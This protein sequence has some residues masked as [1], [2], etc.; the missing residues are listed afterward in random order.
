MI[1]L[2]DKEIIDEKI[3]NDE[4][5]ISDSD[6]VEDLPNGKK[7]LAKNSI[8]MLIYNV[9]NVLVPFIYGIYVARVLPENLIGEVTIAQNIAQYF[10]ILAFLGIPTYG[11]REISKNRGNKE[12]T[13]KIFTELFIINFIS[14][15][16]FA[17]IYFGLICLVPSYRSNLVLFLITG[18]LILFNILDITWLYEGLEE[19]GFISLRNLIFKILSIIFLFIFVK[20]ENDYLIYATIHVG[21]LGFNYLT[22]ML[23]HRKYVRFDFK[24][25]N[26]KQHIKPILFLVVVN[27]AIEIY[28]LVDVT[29]IGIFKNSESV[30]FYSY[31]SKTQKI[32]LQIISTFT[33]VLV[34]RISLLYKEKRLDEFNKLISKTLLLIVLLSLPMIVGVCFVSKDLFIILYGESYYKSAEILNVLSLLVLISPIGYLLGSRV[35]LVTNNE[36]YMIIPVGSGAVVNVIL[37]AILINTVGVIGAA[38]ASVISELVVCVV[39]ILLSHKY[40]KITIKLVDIIKILLALVLMFTYCFLI[41]NYIDIN[42]YIKLVILIGGAILI[43]FAFLLI[44]KEELT[45]N[46][47]N[48]IIGKVLRR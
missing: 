10:V 20:T 14:S 15:L 32:L 25:L 18:S 26:F 1:K 11:L 29:M 23:F 24:N 19:F 4:S 8:F 9:L 22:N 13:N 48:K 30:T 3:N 35:L 40:F 12:K 39:Y 2:E 41:A 34:P 36:K 16:I 7:S 27:L 42:V 43:Y 6:G 45:F 44:S 17:S 47:W 33:L 37:N 21:C 31:A 28:T 46:A 5:V 38:I